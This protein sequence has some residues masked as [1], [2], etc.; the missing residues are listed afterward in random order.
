MRNDGSIEA[1]ELRRPGMRRILDALKA[2]KE[3]QP[4]P[5]GDAPGRL[6]GNSGNTWRLTQQRRVACKRC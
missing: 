3:E 1:G 2:I 6:G 5:A 4:G